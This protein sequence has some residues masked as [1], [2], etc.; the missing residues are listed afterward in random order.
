MNGS[1]FSKMAAGLRGQQQNLLD[2]IGTASNATQVL[3]LGGRGVED[4]QKHVT[5]LEKAIRQA[6]E[7]DLGICTVC[8]EHVGE[9]WV[10]TNYTNSVCLDHLTGE[11]RR[12]LEAE[13]ELS[14]KVQRAL[15]PERA[16]T[17]SGWEIAAFSQ[18]ASIVSGDYF[19]FLKFRDG[20][21]AIVIADVMGKGM[22]ASMLMA[23]LQASLRIIVPESSS[24][25]QVLERA[26]MIFCHNINL[27]KF[28]TIVVLQLAP[29]SDLVRY[30][31]AGHNPPFLI[32]PSSRSAADLH[33]L[34]PTGAAIGLVEDA[35]FAV[36]TI[37]VSGGG[38][39]LL[40][41][42]GL[43][44]AGAPEGN[45]YGE[46]RLRKELF[47]FRNDAPMDIVQGLM[48]TLRDF[49][50]GRPLHDDTTIVACR[51]TG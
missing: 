30:A 38:T 3:R 39:L 32:S 26:N 24:P 9:S 17:L 23:S 15:L 29:G 49:N 11:E 16:P 25:E 41:T 8:H 7:Q 48:R 34:M 33:S 21:H 50:S 43:V 1:W 20:S 40:S 46:E 35:T 47:G 2:W 19:D 37:T 42:D 14:Q 22:P 31:N 13:L 10:E 28:V 12:R 51:R 27:T 4:L 6:E 18:P 36:E 5:V 44:E 45:Q